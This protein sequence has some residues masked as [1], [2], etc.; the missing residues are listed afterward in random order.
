MAVTLLGEGPGLRVGALGSLLVMHFD[1]RGTLE[2]LDVLDAV[3]AK[4]AA[5][6]PKFSTMVVVTGV[7]LESPAPGVRERSAALDAKYDAQVVGSAIV[8]H[9]AGVAAVFGR[10]FL[11][12]WALVTKRQAPTKT[13]RDVGDAV[14]WLAS[15]EGQPA[16]LP[17]D[18]RVVSA[19]TAFALHGKTSVP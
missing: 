16:G 17:L 4:H 5:A 10:S 12:A 13:F 14:A 7:K 2:A 6:F 3:E 9:V 19:V 11:A 18:S 15:L 1:G 8:V